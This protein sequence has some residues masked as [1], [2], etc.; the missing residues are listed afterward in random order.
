QKLSPEKQVAAVAE[1]LQELN[2]GFDGKLTPTIT[3]GEVTGLGIRSDRIVDLSPVRAL[4]ALKNLDCRPPQTG[5]RG[6]LSDLSPLAGLRLAVLSVPNTSVADL[7]PLKGMPLEALYFSGTPVESLA[8]LNGMKLAHLSCNGTRIAD[9]APL[10]GMPLTTLNFT[11]CPRLS[12]LAPLEGMPLHSLACP[13][14][15]VVDLAP[16]KGMSLRELSFTPGNIVSGINVIRQMETLD[17]IS[18]T[19]R[20]TD[21]MSSAEF[22]KRYDAGEFGKPSASAATAGYALD[23]SPERK[24]YVEVPKWKYDGSTPLTIEAW[25]T[26][27]RDKLTGMSI[28]NDNHDSKTWASL[29]VGSTGKWRFAYTPTEMVESSALVQRNR[30]HLAG[31]FDGQELSLYV[32]GVRQNQTKSVNAP[33]DLTALDFRIGAKPRNTPAEYVSFFDGTID[34]LRISSVARYTNDFTPQARFEPDDQTELLYHFDEGSGT[35]AKDSSSHHRDGKI[36]GATWVAGGTAGTTDEADRRLAEWTRNVAKGWVKIEQNG[37]VQLV[38]SQGAALPT[39]AYR[40][41]DVDVHTKNVTDDDLPI[42]YGTSISKVNLV[43]TKVTA[44]G[45]AKLQ[46]ALPNCNIIWHGA[47]GSSAGFA[48]DFSPERKS[49]VEVPEWKYDGGTPLT[50]EAWVTPRSLPTTDGVAAVNVLTNR[51]SG[52]FVLGLST[53]SQQWLF[54]IE[55]N[56]G[57][58]GIQSKKAQAGKQ[59]HLA[60]VFAD[61]RKRLYLDGILAGDDSV[62]LPFKPSGREVTIGSG[63]ANGYFDGTIDEVR[64]SSVARYSNDFT[65]QARFE[66]DD[67]TELLYHFDEGSGTVAKD[68]SSH[69]RD[70]KISGA[71]WAS[72]AAQAPPELPQ[73]FI[74]AADKGAVDLVFFGDGFIQRWGSDGKTSWDKFFAPHKTVNLGL[75]GMTVERLD[76]ILAQWRVGTLDP[77]LLILQISNDAHAHRENFAVPYGQLLQQLRALFP[78]A[79]IVVCGS[80]PTFDKS[81]S[82]KSNDLRQANESLRT[83][84]DDRMVFYLDLW[85]AL[86]DAQGNLP[87]D[88]RPTENKIT[89]L[90][91]QRWAEALEPLL[92]RLLATSAPPVDRAG[93]ALDFSPE[94]KSYIKVPDW[95]YDGSTPVTLEA[96]IVLPRDDDKSHY[97]LLSDF[98]NAGIGIAHTPFGPENVARWRFSLYDRKGYQRTQ[99]KALLPEKRPVHLAGVYD[100]KRE[101]RFYVDGNLQQSAVVDGFTPSAS[102][103]LIGADPQGSTDRFQ[104]FRG[105][106]DE[107]RISSVA[108]Y[109]GDFTPQSRFE[110]DDQ[111]EVLYHFDEGSGTVA[112]DASSH[113]RDGKISGA[114]WV[115][116]V[117]PTPLAGAGA[118][119]T[120]LLTSA[121]YA[122]SEPLK[123]ATPRNSCCISG[124]GLSLVSIAYTTTGDQTAKKNDLWISQRASIDAPFPSAV[125]LGNVLNSAGEDSS[126]SLSADGLTLIFA[127]DRPGG[128]GG[129]T[130]LWMATRRTPADS[131]AAPVSLPLPI[132]SSNTEYG[133]ALSADGLT[134]VISSQR[135]GGLGAADLWQSRRRDS[136]S[137]WS[138]PVNLGPAVNSPQ[139]EGRPWLSGDGRV[140]IFPTYEQTK[141]DAGRLK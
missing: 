93:F 10:R 140:L 116:A 13:L 81:N 27:R 107:V 56:N 136:N 70:G 7:S 35:V 88:V 32:D 109:S 74:N 51:S 44:A 76:A 41:L 33:A 135:A 121:D 67:Q 58:K 5:T 83:L 117:L 103:F 43:G 97:A 16:L 77:K 80:Y 139:Q 66:P 21:G 92:T 118:G 20:M 54:S 28:V 45:V 99:A 87:A 39:A 69:H 123:V 114:T 130:D 34:E 141:D 100:G 126:P 125:N 17:R 127:S 96:W 15:A 8:P 91:Y 4:A 98:D 82:P 61:G 23:F 71:T 110:P 120:E 9:L 75:G 64:I 105:T 12:S 112:R 134:L 42:F 2:F 1:K 36:S 31:V 48:L 40:V 59:V 50:V 47:Q 131:F 29:L 101:S 106:I 11:D 55:G 46:Q 138:E 137:A 63:A 132:N 14:T 84:A 19:P 115:A 72:A 38:G 79:K 73:Q 85:P 53:T 86:L 94:R 57:I 68:S 49:Y 6:N 62:E 18:A 22:W 24:S 111:T 104:H 108:R 124:D 129:L 60:G 119:Q 133:A 3:D 102:P 37:V 25:V 65:P 122:W 52:G 90:G 95:K 113:H 78:R 128:S 26:A 30:R 89:P